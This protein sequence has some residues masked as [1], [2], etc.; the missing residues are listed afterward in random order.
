LEFVAVFARVS[1][2]GT[3]VKYS[4]TEEQIQEH[5][6]QT[7]QAYGDEERTWN[8]ESVTW[9]FFGKSEKNGT[10]LRINSTSKESYIAFNSQ[11]YITNIAFNILNGS[12]RE[13]DNSL[14]IYDATTGVS[15]TTVNLNKV[16]EASIAIEGN[17]KNLSIQSGQA[18][19]ISNIVLTCVTPEQ[20]A[21]YATS[22]AATEEIRTHVVTIAASCD[23]TTVCLP[24]NAVAPKGAKFFALKSVDNEGLHFVSTETLVAGQGYVLQGEPGAKYTLKEVTEAVDYNANILKG[25]IEQTNLVDL[26]F[27][28]KDDYNYPWILAKD[29]TFKRYTGEYIPAGKAYLDGALLQNL[30]ESGAATMRVI[31]E[32]ATN[33]QETG[34]SQLSDQSGNNACYYNLQGQ[35][36]AQPTQAGV[37]YIEQGG[38]KLILRK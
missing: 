14:Y 24:Y 20:Y 1:Q 37:L 31:F 23:Y 18:A 7:A 9:R 25:V 30:G 21:G 26:G 38:R 15:V 13:Y 16:K 8:D 11:N 5:F 34:L 4:L 17:H 10:Y 2:K 12:S 28:G 29:G 19:K 3:E 35:R 6:T 33:G 27:T 32:E 36:I 22:I